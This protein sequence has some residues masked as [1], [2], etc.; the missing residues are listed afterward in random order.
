V[1]I[2]TVDKSAIQ[3]GISQRNALRKLA[4][5]PLLDEQKELENACRLIREKRW[6]AFKESRQADYERLRD[7]VYAER[8][9]PSGMIGGWARHIEINKRF[10]AFMRTHC[11]D[12]IA[13]MMDIAPD[14]LAIT[15]QIAEATPQDQPAD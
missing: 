5:L 8:G 15:R 4:L 13:A 14:Y 6:H 3:A 10:E 2:W 7:E 12:E 9:I 1:E 11:A